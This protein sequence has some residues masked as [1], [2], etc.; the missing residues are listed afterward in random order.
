MASEI[1]P[2][3][4]STLEILTA[5]KQALEHEEAALNFDMLGFHIKCMKLLQ[6]ACDHCV[7]AAENDYPQAIYGGMRLLPLVAVQVLRD[8]GSCERQN[9]SMLPHAVDAMRDLIR[10]EGSDEMMEA[11]KALEEIR[12][13]R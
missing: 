7:V 4:T 1:D 3:A 9:A 6:K 10:A 8:L 11:A 5:Y 13:V 2:S 12:G